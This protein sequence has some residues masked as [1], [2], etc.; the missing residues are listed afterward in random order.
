MNK[1]KGFTLIEVL[2]VIMIIAI[3]ASIV[4]VSLDTARQ[5]TRDVTI[6]NQ[7]GQLRSLAEASFTFE[8][9]YQEFKKASEGEGTDGPAFNRAKEKIGEMS[10]LEED[11]LHV[12]FSS[13]KNPNH[14]CMY[15]RL[16]RNENE[17]FCVDSRG[18]A[19]IINTEGGTPFCD[20][21]I[22]CREEGDDGDNGNGNDNEGGDPY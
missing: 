8:K 11:F 9:G 15:A 5:R 16:T 14:Y 17:I 6:Q 19:G 3:L 4:L 21:N 12:H 1:N 2:T 7:V 10:E 20:G 13:D 22:K 18:D